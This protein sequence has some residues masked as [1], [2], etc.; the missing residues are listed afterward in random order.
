MSGSM[1]LL[2]GLP[3]LH[4]SNNPAFHNMELWEMPHTPP[5]PSFGA[6]DA[7]KQFN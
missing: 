7:C 1:E 6:P 4:C 2:K 5:P 3:L